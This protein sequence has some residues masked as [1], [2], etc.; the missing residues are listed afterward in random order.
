MKLVCKQIFVLGKIDFKKNEIYEIHDVT[1]RSKNTKCCA[2]KYDGLII[3]IHVEHIKLIFYS[4]NE[5]RILK[6]NNI[7]NET[8]L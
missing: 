1:N 6:I 8:S 4:I 7:I 5:T 2:I 3:Y